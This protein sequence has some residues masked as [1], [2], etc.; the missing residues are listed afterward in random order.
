ML[1]NIS[2]QTIERIVNSSC[3]CEKYPKFINPKLKHICTAD[4]NLIK[5]INLKNLF[6]KGSKFRPQLT[7]PTIDEVITNI[8]NN[9]KKLID[10]ISYTLNVNQGNFQEW[11]NEAINLIK[12]QY[13]DWKTKKVDYTFNQNSL[14]QTKWLKSQF[15][16]VP[17]DKANNIF[18]FVCK[19]HYFCEMK[20][21]ITTTRTYKKVDDNKDTII[22][23]HNKFYK[24]NKLSHSHSNKLPYSYGIVKLHKNPPKLRFISSSAACSMKSLSVLLNKI[25]NWAT[26]FLQ[27]MW[28][29]CF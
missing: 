12:L 17:A 1:K 20:K 18:V 16:I 2:R 10:K 3:M 22:K 9:L 15:M 25:F 21:E 11:F 14:K 24:D 26:Q 6:S 7:L 29:K 23:I 4:L 19:K 27:T 8:S 5:D 28:K 13:K